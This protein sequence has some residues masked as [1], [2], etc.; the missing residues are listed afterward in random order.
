M[1]TVRNGDVVE[2]YRDYYMRSVIAMAVWKGKYPSLWV[3][4]GGQETI[5]N[6]RKYFGGRFIIDNVSDAA[7]VKL[8]TY[9]GVDANGISQIR[10]TYANDSVSHVT[11][12]LRPHQTF[13]LAGLSWFLSHT[14]KPALEAVGTLSFSFSYSSAAYLIQQ[15]NPIAYSFKSSP[16][17]TA[18]SYIISPL[19][20][21]DI[22]VTLEAI[23][24]VSSWFESCGAV[25]T[26][27]TETINEH[28]DATDPSNIVTYNSYTYTTT[29]DILLTDM[30]YFSNSAMIESLFN[31]IHLGDNESDYYWAGTA[32]D[33][34]FNPN[35]AIDTT[36][37][38]GLLWGAEYKYSGTSLL[39]LNQFSDGADGFVI[40][41]GG[42]FWIDKEK[43][44]KTHPDFCLVTLGNLFNI[45]VDSKSGGFFDTFVGGFLK[46]FIAIV[47]VTVDAFGE[48]AYSALR[49]G[50][51]FILDIAASE[52][53][54]SKSSLESFK[55]IAKKI[56]GTVVVALITYGIS[57]KME[58]AKLAALEAT[59]AKEG[60][61]G[62]YAAVAEFKASV[63]VGMSAFDMGV[64]A[65]NVIS[66][67]F[68]SYSE[69]T[70]AGAEVKAVEPEKKEQKDR[71]A[72]VYDDTDETDISGVFHDYIYDIHD[73]D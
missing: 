32:W 7:K 16:H 53:W 15:S 58:G 25:T 56:L 29:T 59:A 39:W 42:N 18:T 61:V 19:S 72:F 4:A 10:S 37:Y 68:Q 66:S 17:A 60:T 49:L 65:L 12:G 5:I 35:P 13:T 20:D 45:G 73:A 71:I 1:I 70:G 43:W 23:F 31:V 41:S 50:G 21:A 27:L 33:V 67:G 64:K 69:V 11:L 38:A 44:M 51:L 2:G 14:V 28:V 55:H 3:A 62:A 26:T 48:L 9:S 8:L 24:R 46:M 52:G 30:S 57:L 47:G 40:Y 22:N 6:G 54:I 34:D 63:A 36:N